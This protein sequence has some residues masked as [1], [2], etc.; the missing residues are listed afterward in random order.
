[1]RR[2]VQIN[3]AHT[4]P[5]SSRE[6]SYNF[7]IVLSQEFLSQRLQSLLRFQFSIYMTIRQTT[8]VLHPPNTR[9]LHGVKIN[10]VVWVCLRAEDPPLWNNCAFISPSGELGSPPSTAEPPRRSPQKKNKTLSQIM[11]LL[12]GG[13]GEDKNRNE[14]HLIIFSYLNFKKLSPMA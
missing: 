3:E 8:P 11:A 13:R 9:V 4:F 7:H 1:M 5:Y 6:L 10:L 14:R 12:Y 2:T